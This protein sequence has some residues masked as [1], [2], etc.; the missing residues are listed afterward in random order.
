MGNNQQRMVEQRQRYALRKYTVGVVSVLVGALLLGGT[1]GQAHA[2]T[3]DQT[4]TNVPAAQPTTSPQSAAQQTTAPVSTPA[5]TNEQPATPAN[6]QQG[7]RAQFN[8]ADW[9]YTS[10]SEGITLNSYHGQGTDYY[11]PNAASFRR[12]G[13][14]GAD[15]RVLITPYFIRD[16]VRGNGGNG[17]ATSIMIEHPTTV[18]DQLVATDSPWMDTFA[19]SRQLQRVDLA[20]LNVSQVR[21]MSYLFAYDP[22]L[23]TV[24]GLENWD[25]TNLRYAYNFFAHDTNLIGSSKGELDLSRWQTENLF[26]CDRMFFRS[27]IRRVNVS[28]WHLD[29]GHGFTYEMFA[30]L[31]HPA[32][33]IMNNFNAG[34]ELRARDFAGVQPLVVISNMDHLLTLNQQDNGQGGQGHP[35]NTVTFV[36]TS[37]HQQLGRQQQPFVY[38]NEQALNDRLAAI[39]QYA[40]VASAIPDQ[41]TQ[42]V[43]DQDAS[44][45]NGNSYSGVY[46]KLAG[47]YAVANQQYGR[48]V[49]V[50]AAGQEVASEPVNGGQPVTIGET[51]AINPVAPAGWELVGDYPQEYTAMASGDQDV[52]VTVQKIVTEPEE[53]AE[54][55]STPVVKPEAPGNGQVTGT[56][57]NQPATSQPAPADAQQTAQLPQT[58]NDHGTLAA[59][60][61]LAVLSLLGLAGLKK[62]HE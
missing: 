52:L 29:N 24:D 42:V 55:P 39:P 45:V 60:S 23:E 56:V 25:V 2:A 44:W 54:K 61:G 38:R 15:Q 13:K 58:G 59:A 5:T 19:D 50:D 51:V 41:L 1:A 10:S 18:S 26:D 8:V 46:G 40:N 43:H 35:A 48:I 22:V 53:P 16:L 7:A 37:D 62:K 12:A 28:N 14:I 31:V 36:R 30:Q 4:A 34:N 21:Y 33:I 11:L 32:T 49:Y 27:G 47:T 20:G 3:V 6:Q 17:P 57:T 9:G